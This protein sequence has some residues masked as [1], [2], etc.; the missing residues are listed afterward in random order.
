MA[1]ASALAAANAAI[2]AQTPFTVVKHRDP[3]LQIQETAIFAVNQGASSAVVQK[4][5]ASSSS[6]SE[7]SWQIVSP[8][9]SHLL[10]KSVVSEGGFTITYRPTAPQVNGGAY[11][12]R[13]VAGSVCGLRQHPLATVCNAC[14]LTLNGSSIS[15]QFAPMIHALSK[16]SYRGGAEDRELFGGQEPHKPDYLT[17]YAAGAGGG[18]SPFSEFANTE[19]ETSRRL[20]YWVD[21]A[22]TA[23]AADARTQSIVV[24]FRSPLMMSP[25]YWGEVEKAAFS[26]ISRLSLVLSWTNLLRMLSGTLD[27]WI[28]GGAGLPGVGNGV[29]RDGTD[30]WDAGAQAA[31]IAN[32]SVQPLGA[33][34]TFIDSISGGW[35]CSA[36]AG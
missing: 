5:S 23:V 8:G 18:R 3:R 28:T 19:V 30:P 15:C 34:A 1:E 17:T 11:A 13:P 31:S 36:C 35:R 7:T 33:S 21:T 32:F 6:S 2:V 25:L 14:T 16:F 22:N 29:F 27:Q 12:P 9:L 24:R 10:S 4:F 20:E 26:N